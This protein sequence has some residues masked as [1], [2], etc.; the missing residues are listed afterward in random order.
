MPP[1]RWRLKFYNSLIN[2]KI[3][4]R[5]PLIGD[6]AL[7]NQLYTA[8]RPDFSALNQ[9][10]VLRMKIPKIFCIEEPISIAA[11]P[12]RDPMHYRD[13]MHHQILKMLSPLRFP[14]ALCIQCAIAFS[15]LVLAILLPP[16]PII[17]FLSQHAPLHKGLEFASISMALMIFTVGWFSFGYERSIRFQVLACAFLGIAILDLI[18]SLSSQG[19]PN[20]SAAHHV[21]N[22]VNF[23][24][25]SRLANALILLIAIRISPHSNLKVK[26]RWIM[27]A[28]MLGLVGVLVLSGLF[29]QNIT[30]YHW[31]AYLN[32]SSIKYIEWILI[33]LYVVIL[34][35]MIRSWQDTH[36][37]FQALLI[38]G[39]WFLLI[40][41]ISLI[42]HSSN[43]EIYHL[44]GQICKAWGDGFIFW[45]VYAQAMNEP[46]RRLR[47]SKRVLARVQS[48]TRSLFR[49]NQVILDSVS[50]GIAFVKDRHFIRVNSYAETL[51]GYGSGEMEGLSTEIIYADR[52]SYRKTGR[53]IA[54][55]INKGAC[56]IGEV[57]LVRRDGSHFWC[58]MRGHMLAPDQ[59]L[60]GFIWTLEDITERR[61]A[62]ESLEEAKQ[63]LQKS[64][65]RFRNIFMASKV[66]MLIV[67]PH[68][69]KIFD[70]NS[71]ACSYYG[72]EI[73]ELREMP[74]GNINTLP[75][76]EI[77]AELAQ[78]IEQQRSHFYFQHRLAS[79]EIRH[80]EVHTGT[81][82]LED[83]VLLY[84]IIHDITDRRFIEEERYKLYQAIQQSPLSIVITDLNGNIEYVN[85]TLLSTTGYQLDEVLGEY[86]KVLQWDEIPH[87][88]YLAL[89][90]AMSQGQ[91][92]RG[93]IKNYKKNGDLYWEQVQI[94]SIFDD[95]G[96]MTHYLGLKEDI[97]A[98]KLDEDARRDSEER[99]QRVLEGSN[100]GFWDWDISSDEVLY[101]R[102]WAGMLGYDLQEIA[103][104]M[105]AREELIHPDDFPKYQMTLHRHL[106]GS[107]LN[108]QCEYRMK[109]K[110]GE[111]CWILDRGKVTSRN[112]QGKPLRMAG[113][114]TDLT[115]RRHMEETLRNTLVMV[116]RHDAQMVALKQMNDLLLSCENCEQAYAIIARSADRLFG[117]YLG[118]LAILVESEIHCVAHWGEPL[119]LPNTFSWT[120]CWALQLGAT[121]E[122]SNP[123]QKTQCQ[124]F[125]GKPPDTY[126]CVPLTVRGETHGLLHVGAATTLNDEELQELRTLVIAIGES[127]KLTI[128]NLKLRET[129]REQA[130]RDPLTG[131]FNRRYLDETLPRELHR[132]QR[133][134]ES[135]AAAMLDV[136]HF[137]RFNDAYGHDAGD[138][139]LRA[140]GALL[141]S[142]LRASDIACRYGGEELTI[143]LPGSNLNDAWTRLDGLRQTIMQLKIPFQGGELPLITVSIGVTVAGPHEI[144]A[145]SVISRADTALYRA[146]ANGRNQVVTN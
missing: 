52:T 53:H 50:I 36:D 138:T 142:S 7:P 106:A 135:L 111:W 113:T 117:G 66:A 42:L 97:T 67:D 99:L 107:T 47:H 89:R 14:R 105:Q 82:E 30:L 34:V 56:F 78:A 136:D 8:A 51:F 25:P 83:R 70:A 108:Y 16:L 139:V 121:H 133:V 132:H 32:L 101:S 48:K 143:I 9:I 91:T 123:T 94:S 10:A 100:D 41:Q 146:K 126:F 73:D 18:Y 85:P 95:Q 118:G 119:V 11:Q 28:A 109:T 43:T 145:F 110:R 15:L 129:L 93:I 88:E 120:D 22:L 37:E 40:S 55:I 44:T 68:S 76:E 31:F 116:K 38:A 58:L 23:W 19:I 144:D 17:S 29:L 128:S 26:L 39:L 64:E 80:V 140:I 49:E 79:G 130:I 59:P 72:Y 71:A 114:H 20:L 21:E 90:E 13:L 2:H 134:G 24:L 104:N 84:S 127:I 87:P 77:R 6:C 96:R 54:N 124:H 33:I 62:H 86:F 60:A 69:M 5:I 46:Y 125:T 4:P 45:A 98:Q 61:Q 81:L 3:L 141:K 102:R 122:I 137:K 63:V 27:L 1:S 103:A 12:D 57:E 92:W 75:D 65:Q 35:L 112:A 115:E 131:L 74:I